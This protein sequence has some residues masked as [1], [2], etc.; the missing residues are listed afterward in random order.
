[1][2]TPSGHAHIGSLRGPLI[3]DF[4]YKSLE[5][6]REKV[7]FTYV[8]NDFDTIDGLPENLSDKFSKYLGFPLKTAPSPELGFESFADYFA[9][10]FKSVLRNL[11]IT[12]RVL[13]SW[14]MYHEGKFDN[15]IK[16]VL[17]NAEKIQDIYQKI[18][19]SRK[20]EQG[21]LPFQVIC[22]A[23]GK[24]GTTRV[25]AWDGKE[26]SYKCE[27][28]LVVWA[29]GCG[30]EG[31][32]SP[33][34]GTGKLPWKVDWPAHWKVMGVTI[35]GAGKDH[36]SAGGSYDIAMALCKEVFKYPPP[37]KFAY[38]FFLI[39]GKKMASS[40][41]LG[42]KAHDVTKILP[43]PVARL[44]F[45]RTDYREA[46][47]FNPIGTMAIPDLFDEY[48]K[49]ANAYWDKSDENLARIF[50]L[51][52]IKKEVPK[53]MYL[54]RF[55]DVV[56]VIQ[57][58]DVKPEDYFTG[59]KTDK[60]NK[61]EREVLEER[62]KYAKVWLEEYAPDDW[63]F[64]F[65]KEIPGSVS[66]LSNEQKKY[67]LT[68]T[69]LIEQSKD[70]AELETKMYEL[71]QKTGISAKDAFSAIYLSLIGKSYGPKAAWLIFGVGKEKVLKRF[72]E[73]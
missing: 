60:L 5:D 47:E 23:C 2:F 9:E 16:E 57:M 18:S 6:L 54:P 19:G 61:E 34:G 70:A 17:D 55:R 56:Q 42:L 38:E 58:P 1:M 7:E 14:D 3:H 15:V 49:A 35:E 25:F 45:A 10:D 26:V 11:G 59:K 43:A 33:F 4:I 73:I 21:W 67:L 37:Y 24:L 66:K 63:V 36:A 53:K 69:D 71:S 44:L 65:K 51:S 64:E 29:E 28:N 22:E 41:G 40:K 48:D 62:I 30:H 31:K 68:L 20:K 52:Q 46:I 8:F 50:E 72:K 27:P 13:H 39:G 32:I 12:P